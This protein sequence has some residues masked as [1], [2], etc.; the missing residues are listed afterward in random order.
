MTDDQHY[1]LAGTHNKKKE[2][3]QNFTSRDFAVFLIL[4]GN[5]PEIPVLA[6]SNYLPS[7]R[8]LA[9]GNKS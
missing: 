4:T 1:L 8:G 9:A 2:F 7:V 6:F 5:A 3:S